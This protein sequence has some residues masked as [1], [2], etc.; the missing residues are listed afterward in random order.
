[1]NAT[2]TARRGALTLAL[3]ADAAGLQ[4]LLFVWLEII[5]RCAT[6]EL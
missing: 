4:A 6:L 2:I 1:L 3:L 5:I